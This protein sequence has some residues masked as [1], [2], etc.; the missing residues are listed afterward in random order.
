MD[1]ANNCRKRSKTLKIPVRTTHYHHINP[2]PQFRRNWPTHKAVGNSTTMCPICLWDFF[3]EE[4]QQQQQKTSTLPNVAWGQKF[5]SMSQ[6]AGGLRLHLH[7]F[8]SKKVRCTFQKRAFIK[9]ANTSQVTL[10]VLPS[11]G[12]CMLC[13][14]VNGNDLL[15]SRAKL[16]VVTTSWITT[17]ICTV[18]AFHEVKL[19]LKKKKQP[20][21]LF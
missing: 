13:L 9:W 20:Y 17:S 10:L 1:N 7:T 21:L 18:W 16:G 8:G 5:P 14:P 19:K 6:K 15:H 3:L 2:I 12:S 4:Q 11:S